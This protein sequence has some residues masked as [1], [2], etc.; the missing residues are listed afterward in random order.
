MHGGRF[1]SSVVLGH[2]PRAE[3]ESLRL[4]SAPRPLLFDLSLLVTY[5]ERK[6]CRPWQWVKTATAPA[7]VFGSGPCPQIC[8]F[9]SGRSGSEETIAIPVDRW[10]SQKPKQQGDDK[11]SKT[12]VMPG[13]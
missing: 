3:A 1:V 12:K 4:S 2:L 11:I 7:S 8:P 10:W 6:L 13:M 9:I 5:H